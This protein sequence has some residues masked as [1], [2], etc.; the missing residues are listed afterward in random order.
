VKKHQE[1]AGLPCHPILF[2][3][4]VNKYGYETFNAS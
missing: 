3:Y 4:P 2:P 1:F